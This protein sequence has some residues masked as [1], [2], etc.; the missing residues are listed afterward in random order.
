V[1]GHLIG[2]KVAEFYSWFTVKGSAE[3]VDDFMAF[4]DQVR[5]GLRFA[6]GCFKEGC[7]RRVGIWL[8]AWHM[9]DSMP[10]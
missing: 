1:V 9:C 3:L 7:A 10:L 5:I 4:Q 6:R 8:V 2:P